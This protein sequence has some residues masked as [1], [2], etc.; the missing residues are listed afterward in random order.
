[1]KAISAANHASVISLLT[2]GYPVRDIEGRTG[3]GKSTVHRI[4]KEVDIDKENNPGGHPPKLSTRDKA[5]IIRQI[6]LGKLDTAV[7]AT[8]FINST[9]SHPVHPQT[10]RRALQESGFKSATKK[11]VPM[12]KKTHRQRR[13]EFAQQHENWTVEDWKRVLWTDKDKQDWV[14]W[15]GVCV[16]T[17][18]GIHLRS[19]HIT[20]SEAW[21]GE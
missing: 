11:K 21:R 9:L 3:L 7:Q 20:N 5:S 12:L 19:Y 13:L 1:M 17:K 4:K 8:H 10:V 18:G 16:E 6:R 14:R 2:Q 15:E